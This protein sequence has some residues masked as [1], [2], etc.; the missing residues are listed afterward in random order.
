MKLIGPKSGCAQAVESS[1][2][3][4]VLLLAAAVF[5]NGCGWFGAETPQIRRHPVQDET[6]PS[7]EE[8]F[9]L[10]G[11]QPAEALPE[12][13]GIEPEPIDLEQ[14]RRVSPASFEE[15]A[16][17]A[18]MH[19]F[20]AIYFEPGSAGLDSEA[21][22]RL[23]EH[24]QWLEQNP[25]VFVELAGYDA[26]SATVEYAY[27]L[28]MA[29]ALSVQEFLIKHGITSLR[30]FP[31]GYGMHF[32]EVE[33]V[34]PDANALNCRVELTGFLVPPGLDQPPTMAA[35]QSTAPPVVSP[36]APRPTE[37]ID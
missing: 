11:E 32:P 5:L 9:D 8:A 21:Q 29:R 18:V 15:S 27:N 2:I 14:E 10:P 4:F 35:T 30:L 36:P 17:T 31:I 13:A 28:A 33:G 3:H 23:S 1:R 20:E 22:R 7:P 12:E 24:A 37:L 6:P 34:T 16:E 26:L 25:D 19:D